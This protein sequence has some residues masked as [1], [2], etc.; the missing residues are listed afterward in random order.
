[1]VS[2]GAHRPY[3]HLT[4]ASRPPGQLIRVMGLLAIADTI[5]ESAIGTLRRRPCGEVCVH[6]Q[7]SERLLR[8][9]S[10][11]EVR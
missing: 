3:T 11:A 10:E 4:V 9:D 2:L 7:R 6:K 8:R 1:M 5:A